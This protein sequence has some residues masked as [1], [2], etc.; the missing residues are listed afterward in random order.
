MGRAREVLFVSWMLLLRR[1]RVHSQT[2]G[3]HRF[4]SQLEPL[5]CHLHLMVKVPAGMILQSAV[6]KVLFLD[7]CAAGFFPH[8]HQSS[9]QPLNSSVYQLRIFDGYYYLC[10]LSP[11]RR[12]AGSSG[13]LAKTRSC[14]SSCNLSFQLMMWKSWPMCLGQR[15]HNM[16]MC[17]NPHFLPKRLTWRQCP[18][19][20]LLFLDLHIE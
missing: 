3:P 12:R 20:Q 6:H 11:L 5:L 10:T 19:P 7:L 14:C 1:L 15:G 13:S 9:M 17:M 16:E 18:L 2:L 8:F 4:Q